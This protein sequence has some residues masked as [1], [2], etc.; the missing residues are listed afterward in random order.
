M[1]ECKPP[2]ASAIRSED[3]VVFLA[4]SIEMGSASNW[5]ATLVA[6]LADT[7]VVI[8]NPRR[9]EWDASWRQSLDEPRFVEQV[10]WELDHL[11]RADVIAMWFDPSTKSPITLLELGLHARSGKVVVGCPAGF[12]RRGNLEVVCA[13][14]SI[15]LV[16]QWDDFVA[17]VRAAL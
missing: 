9:E 10:T 14:Y 6:A 8:C 11:D 16:A 17:K 12:W 13:R 2:A 3:R 4:G 1:R 15:P 5:Q 7:E